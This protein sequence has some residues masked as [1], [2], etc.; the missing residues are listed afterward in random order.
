MDQSYA[1][2]IGSR[3]W[4]RLH[5]TWLIWPVIGL[6]MMTGFAFAYIGL[7]AHK[8]QWLICGVAYF[9]VA[10]VVLFSVGTEP[11]DGPFTIADG[12]LVGLWLVGM[13]HA[14]LVNRTWLTQLA[15]TKLRPWYESEAPPAVTPPPAPPIGNVPVRQRRAPIDINNAG[16]HVLGSLPGMNAESGHALVVYRNSNGPFQSV[17]EFAAA[18]GISP[19][20]LARSR[21]QLTCGSGASVVS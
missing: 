11:D 15:R 8:T 16:A 19:E 2:T 3:R 13:V 5:S 10:S 17:E 12:S 14:A 4:R 21:D 7:R 9:L 20:D 6:G 18:A 1:Q